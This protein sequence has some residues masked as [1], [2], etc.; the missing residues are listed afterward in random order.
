MSER[1][2]WEDILVAHGI[3]P[4][5][6]CSPA[7]FSYEEVVSRISRDATK[8]S[9]TE[10]DLLS[11]TFDEPDPEERAIMDRYKYENKLKY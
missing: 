9:D 7:P 5:K 11:E 3:I 2:E 4:P 1:T 8:G 10:D 6:P